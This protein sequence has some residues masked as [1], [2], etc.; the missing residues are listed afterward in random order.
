MTKL[1]RERLMGALILAAVLAMPVACK[2]SSADDGVPGAG[3]GTVAKASTPSGRDS[4]RDD[5][6]A[7]AAAGAHT[8]LFIG[9][10]LTAGVGPPPDKADPPLLPQKGGSA[11]LPVDVLDA[12]GGGAATPGA[13]PRP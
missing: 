7:V 6:T 9:T 12:R 4:V 5:A 13:L 2:R 1:G 8:L 3:Q 11:H 10:S